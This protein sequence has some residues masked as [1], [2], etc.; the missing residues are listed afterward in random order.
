MA[1]VE[2]GVSAALDEELLLDGV[3]LEALSS[4]PHAAVT[5]TRDSAEAARPI[6]TRFLDMTK[7]SLSLMGWRRDD[8]WL[9]ADIGTSAPGRRWMGESGNFL[10]ALAG[11]AF[12]Q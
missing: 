5:K 11:K 8:W 2:L 9:A 6:R 10:D 7:Y 1:G 4:L 12:D 3:P